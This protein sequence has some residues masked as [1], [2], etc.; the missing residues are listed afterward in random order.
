VK[1]SRLERVGA[2]AIAGVMLAFAL[3]TQLLG[4]PP[5]SIAGSV[6]SAAPD[7]RRALYLLFGAQGYAPEAWRKFPGALPS[8]EHVLL[9]AS[10]PH[11]AG[12]GGDDA[13]EESNNDSE[14][15]D[16]ESPEDVEDATDSTDAAVPAD[17]RAP[18]AA[19]EFR[20]LMHYRRFVESG[21]TLVLP[22]GPRAL[23]FLVEDLECEPCREIAV[24]DSPAGPRL[25]HT[26]SGGEWTAQWKFDGTFEALD[27]ASDVRE[28][29]WGGPPG[30]T[31]D[32]H[33]AV[34][35]PLGNGRIVVLGDDG[36]LEN[37]RLGQDD[38]ALLAVALFEELSR[39][40]RLLFDEYALGLW[41][42]STP[43]QIATGPSLVL[44][45]AHVFLLLALL[46]WRA[47][48][49]LRFPRDPIP[50]AQVSPILRARSLS[51]LFER[52][53]RVD[54]LAR[55]LRMGALRTLCDRLHIS[56]DRGQRLD[57]ASTFDSVARRAGLD[58]AATDRWRGAFTARSIT[59]D[60]ELE[61]L[62]R[63]LAALEAAVDAKVGR[64]SPSA[65]AAT[66]TTAAKHTTAATTS[67]EDSPA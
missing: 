17:D 15:D 60:A 23:E 6:D 33:F 12:V 14:S 16:T 28:L 57:A 55:L 1:W 37:G 38:H 46:V 13:E 29:W 24:A 5:Q 36:F 21:G 54:V 4:G 48:W 20:S 2:I 25:V 61:A 49:T 59:S 30:G 63:E 22:A 7:G 52:A 40:G 9:L 43:I 44:A 19:L 39:G 34:Q 27:P 31:G 11:A 67:P 26:S 66:H 18:N 41:E 8:G 56:V 51:S 35:V 32:E 62:G 42:A 10:A 58:A 53:E 47:A 3:V 50:L 64:R 65:R 45:S